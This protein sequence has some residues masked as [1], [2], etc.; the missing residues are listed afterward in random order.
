MASLVQD[1]LPEDRVPSPVNSAEGGR[2]HHYNN[3][4]N[5][6]LS[7][8]RIAS[9]TGSMTNSSQKNS[10]NNGDVPPADLLNRLSI[11]ENKDGQIRVSTNNEAYQQYQLGA[12]MQQQDRRRGGGGTSKGF[13][14]SSGLTR[15]DDIIRSSDSLEVQLP[16]PR[17]VEEH[18]VLDDDGPAAAAAAAAGGRPIYTSPVGVTTGGGFAGVGLSSGGNRKRSSAGSSNSN[19]KAGGG[20]AGPAVAQDASKALHSL[21]ASASNDR[22]SGGSRNRGPSLPARTTDDAAAPPSTK[23]KSTGSNIDEEEYVEEDDEDSSEVSASD[24]DGSWISWFC[25]LRGNEFFCEVDEDYIQVGL[26]V[27]IRFTS[28]ALY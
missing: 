18:I 20:P 11:S 1:D 8:G 6:S 24:E 27:K 17:E 16:Q 15:H 26:P 7:S 12:D 10:N 21:Q 23:T 28:V 9:P 3:R 25:S 14:L 19:N 22:V 5:T 13:P 2:S 4:V